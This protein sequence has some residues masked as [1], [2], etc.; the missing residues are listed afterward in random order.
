MFVNG[1]M[2]GYS[3]RS[4]VLKYCPA[5]VCLKKEAMHGI[6]GFVVYDI[7]GGKAI[8]S[9][10]NAQGAWLNALGWCGRNRQA[11]TLKVV[12][13]EDCPLKPDKL[14]WPGNGM[15]S[16]CGT[17]VIQLRPR[18]L[19]KPVYYV[20]PEKTKVTIPDQFILDEF[21]EK[22]AAQQH[23]Q[24]IADYLHNQREQHGN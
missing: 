14:V 9:A 10:G 15:R 8:G 23:C 13:P 3:P 20:V 6:R 12:P 17:Y 21:R 2:P 18:Q 24:K 7:P 22:R 5:A 11:G 16:R 1:P 19:Q 4:E